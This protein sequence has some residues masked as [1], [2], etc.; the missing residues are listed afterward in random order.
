MYK[1]TSKSTRLLF[2]LVQLRASENAMTSLHW[3]SGE[4]FWKE[5]CYTGTEASATSSR[6]SLCELVALLSLAIKIQLLA[7]GNLGQ[8]NV[9]HHCPDNSQARCFRR[10]GINLIGALTNIAK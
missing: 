8:T 5:L 2:C 6:P 9:L 3:I 10:K 4:S 1:E 7:N